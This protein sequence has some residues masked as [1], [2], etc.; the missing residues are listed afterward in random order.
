MPEPDA[1]I[2]NTISGFLTSRGRSV[3]EI[4]RAADQTPD[5][6]V[7]EN[8]P[9]TALVEI[10]L[11]TDDPVEMTDL[12]QQ[13]QT[14]E[15]V[16]RSKPTDGWNRLDALVSDA[17]KQMKAVDPGRTM[18]RV[19]WFHCV[20]L[21]SA[22]SEIRLRATIYGSQKLISMEIS[23]VVTAYYFWNSS[24]FRHRAD[25]DGVVISRGDEA[26]IHLNEYSPRFASFAASPLTQAFGPGVWH[27]K[28]STDR[29][30]MICDY[31]GA[32]SAPDPILAFLRE[33][34]RIK[35]LQTID[36]NMHSAM[37]NRPPA[38]DSDAKGE[39]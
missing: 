2:K 39:P 36:M 29:E 4:P 18:H 27:P 21:D 25:L 7:D 31:P 9:D 28:K 22:L 11:K 6:L 5:L 15:I 8:T 32:R 37:M 30:V 1:E 33:K 17:I 34:Y 16:G 38:S 13:L 20:G 14:G 24:F 19:V 35:H 3:K 26:Q 12:S 23:G 10:K